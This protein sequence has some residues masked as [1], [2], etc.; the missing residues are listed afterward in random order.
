M[1][2]LVEIVDVK[3]HGNAWVARATFACPDVTETIELNFQDPANGVAIK[4][5]ERRVLR[6]AGRV[7]A[8]RNAVQPSG[9]QTWP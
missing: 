8:S 4:P 7:L 5:S 6:E 3:R 1:W 2:T 9:G